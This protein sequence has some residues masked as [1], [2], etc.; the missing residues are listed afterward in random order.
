MLMYIC[1]SDK[2]NSQVDLYGNDCQHHYGSVD[3][4]KSQSLFLRNSGDNTW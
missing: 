3:L 2:I 1:T 4:Y